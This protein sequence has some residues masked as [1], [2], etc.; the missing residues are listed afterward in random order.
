MKTALILLALFFIGG[1]L[2]WVFAGI[3]KDSDDLEDT[4]KDSR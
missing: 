3:E 1:G 2:L 4:E